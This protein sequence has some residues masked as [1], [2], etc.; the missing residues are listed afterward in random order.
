MASIRLF[1]A[2][3]CV[4]R[5]LP[6]SLSPTLL[7][8]AS[9]LLI[10]GAPTS[11]T[12]QALWPVP[13]DTVQ[14]TAPR[15]HA[16]ESRVRRAGFATVVPLG[17]RAPAG[18]DLGDLLDRIVGVQVHR[19]GGLGSFSLAGVRGSSPG[20]VLVCIDGVPLASAGDGFV[21]LARLPASSFG[22]AEIYRGAQVAS[23]GG[24]PAAGVIN[25]VTPTAGAMPWRLTL[26][27][28][29]FGT[30]VARGQWG[31]VRGPLAALFS[32]QLRRSRGDFRYL[33]RNGTLFGNN[34]DDRMVRRANSDFRDAAFLGKGSWR[35]GSPPGHDDTTG[36]PCVWRLDYTGQR[37]SRDGGVPGTESVQ[38]RHVRFRSERMR[39]E[40]SL[41]GT[42]L[43]LEAAAH[44]DRSRDRFD[45]RAGEVGL[46]RAATD[47][48][49]RE[50]GA[51][52]AWTQPL[53]VVLQ[54]PR[55]RVDLRNERR[56]PFDLLR[57]ERGF[58][59][60]RRHRTL[61]IEDR[62]FLGPLVV[63]G[64]YRWARA[65]DNY[66][67]PTG[68]MAGPAP[69]GR[70]QRDE[71]AAFGLRLDCGK[72]WVVKA[73][74]GRLA[75]FPTFPELF[76]QNG[77]QEGN[78]ALRPERGVQWDLGASW[79]PDRPWRCEV[80]FFESLVEGRI[81]LLQN[82]QRT[83][84]AMN[85]DRA[86]VRGVEASG[87]LRVPLPRA[88]L[89]LT[90]STT[91]QGARDISLTPVYHGKRL[92]NLPALE[93]FL[94]AVL[95]RGAWSA[96]WDLAA[97]TSHFRD[98]YNSQAKRSPGSTTHDLALSRTI[99]SGV[100]RIRA[101]VRNLLDQRREDIDGFPLPGRSFLFEITVGGGGM[102]SPSVERAEED[103]GPRNRTDGARKDAEIRDRVDRGPG[104][105]DP[106]TAETAVQP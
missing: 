39:H 88:V 56:L 91:W 71:G 12:A 33:D 65:A 31:G 14:V 81:F 13:L 62:A 80:A 104:S 8:L 17:E 69:T 101:E 4:A 75:R 46:G 3:V 102:T 90:S 100:A 57:G 45:N 26:S 16:A 2:A 42:L 73:N 32:G 58:I 7:S 77:V 79:A 23:C 6:L 49:T 50:E 34:A 85:L 52:L 22:Q 105:Q 11:A 55:V 92:P 68:W 84:I 66:G 95:A 1:R 86:W 93:A 47:D 10:L 74:Q 29:S 87:V 18:R 43:R 40:L 36:V 61:A 67:G 37:F 72:G 99:G 70:V 24:P 15:P 51:Y 27:G 78:P 53:R 98:R 89:E 28:G 59:R 30:G 9:L 60:E 94:S 21:D 82:S 96:R 83:V 20:Q 76:G 103:A 38:T 35:I 64:S 19:Y 97:R 63:E 106:D 54:E 5:L 48:R 25:L 41:R 44:L